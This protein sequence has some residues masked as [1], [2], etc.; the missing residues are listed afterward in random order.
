MSRYEEVRDELAEAGISLY[1][2]S[3]ITAFN[4]CSRR[5]DYAYRQ[6]L[7]AANPGSRENMY[8][9]V[10]GHAA[11]AEFYEA[12][13]RGFG[14]EY[15]RTAAY[16][17]VYD[18][19]TK[20]PHHMLL[21]TKL[22]ELLETYFE[23]YEAR[24]TF[25]IISVETV[26]TTPVTPTDHFGAILDLI[27]QYTEGDYK[28]RLAVVD[29][30]FVYNFLNPDVLELDP[31]IPKYITVARANGF[32]VSMGIYNQLRHREMANPSGLDLF[33]REPD[34]SGPKA[35]E[36]IWQQQAN[37]IFKIRSKETPVATLSHMVC[38]GCDF[39]TLCKAELN[40]EPTSTLRTV[41][42]MPRKSREG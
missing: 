7:M 38:K 10:V 29:H 26:Y 13:K 27:I 34:R 19:M 2:N 9:G 21:L 32:P 23:F 17:V 33:R 40:G 20:N 14:E 37:A 41:D 25:K 42:Y 30:K 6:G 24:D 15:A 5:Y 35:R 28:D 39:R 31:Q 12:K 3:G 4:E 36:S 1:S 11:L 8:R 16:S 22:R 18:Q